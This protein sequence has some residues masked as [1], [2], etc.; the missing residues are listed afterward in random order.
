MT[1]FQYS[2]SIPQYRYLV[3]ENGDLSY[4]S[5]IGRLEN[6]HASLSYIAKAAGI[7]DFTE[8]PHENK[9]NDRQPSYIKYYTDETR[10]IVAKK[11]AKDIELFGY[12]FGD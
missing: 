4:L 1:S 5:H 7:S 11:Y 10:E 8:F 9:S 3:G 6:I 12:K 2:H